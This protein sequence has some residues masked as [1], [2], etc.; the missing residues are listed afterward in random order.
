MATVVGKVTCSVGRDHLVLLAKSEN[1]H[2]FRPDERKREL[3]N[4][5]GGSKIQASGQ[6][7]VLG[8]MRDE[9]PGSGQNPNET[10]QGPSEDPAT[11]TCCPRTE[12]T[13]PRPWWAGR[14]C[15]VSLLLGER[16]GAR[17]VWW[18]PPGLGEPPA[19]QSSSSSEACRLQPCFLPGFPVRFWGHQMEDV[20]QTGA[21]LG[22]SICST[23]AAGLVIRLTRMS[24]KSKSRPRLQE[25]WGRWN[26]IE[27]K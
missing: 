8:Q 2:S 7:S 3:P 23:P 25:P 26:H 13:C 12:A 14:G 15:P 10:T 22:H 24:G 5:P 4:Q 6:K 9:G 1:A 27:P 11:I 19:S 17:G 20:S 21:Y 16:L 18:G